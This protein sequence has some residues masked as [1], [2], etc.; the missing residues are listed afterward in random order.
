MKKVLFRLSAILIMVVMMAGVILPIT[1]V[2]ECQHVWGEGVVTTPATHTS[3]GYKR[4]VCQECGKI[5]VEQIDMEPHVWKIDEEDSKKKVCDCGAT[6]YNM[7]AVDFYYSTIDGNKAT[8]DGNAVYY[9]VDSA[10][11][12]KTNYKTDINDLPIQYVFTQKTG[13]ST[14]AI[15]GISVGGTVVVLV[16]GAALWWFVIKKKKKASEPV[17]WYDESSNSDNNDNDVT[18]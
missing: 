18:E 12:Y 15:V 13:L 2:A 6:E 17:L 3:I 4:Y 9:K 1:V 5:N 14:L 8:L 7:G 10:V 16:G 11:D